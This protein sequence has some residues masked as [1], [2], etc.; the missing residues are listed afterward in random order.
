M[1]AILS[2][3]G[4]TILCPGRCEC[5]GGA[6]HHSHLTVDCHGDPDIDRRQL[7]QQL[8][9]L[10]SSNLSYCH[11]MRLTIKGTPLKHV[12][13]SICRLTMLTRLNLDHNRLT[14][15]PDSCLSNLTALTSLTASN[16]AITELQDGLFDGLDK[17]ITLNLSSNQISSIGL[18][19]FNGSAM[20]T[21]LKE[22]HLNYNRIHTLEPWFLPRD[23]L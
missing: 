4:T 5:S 9:A 1:L 14:R 2:T 6:P 12:P 11:V 18:R 13:L 3:V 23:A 21:S 16:N 10:L 15:L 20:L 7:S 17:L 19:V 22:V 8:D